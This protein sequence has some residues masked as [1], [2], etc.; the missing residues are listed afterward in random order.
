MIPGNYQVHSTFSFSPVLN[1]KSNFHSIISCIRNLA[2]LGYD[3]GLRQLFFFVPRNH[4]KTCRRPNRQT[5]SGYGKATGSYRAVRH[6]LLH[7]IGLKKTLVFYKGKGLRGKKMYWIMNEYGL[8][9]FSSSTPRVGLFLFSAHLPL[10][11]PRSIKLKE[12]NYLLCAKSIMKKS[13]IPICTHQYY[14]K[15][16][17]KFID[18]LYR[19]A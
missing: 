18:L 2:G 3:V 11:L 6:K 15:A 13:T 8:S 7:C 14:L 19:F 5:A 17:D 4:E 1:F 12:H 10:C 9:D 16:I